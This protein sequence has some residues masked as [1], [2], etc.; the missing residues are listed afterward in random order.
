M[1]LNGNG[2]GVESNGYVVSGAEGTQH[3]ACVCACICLYTCVCVCSCVYVCVPMMHAA[4][5]TCICLMWLKARESARAVTEAST[6]VFRV[7]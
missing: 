5:A 2:Y 6:C 3:S 1:V 7:C 4:S